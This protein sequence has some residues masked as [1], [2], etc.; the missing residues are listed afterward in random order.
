LIKAWRN[1]CVKNAGIFIYQQQKIILSF[2]YES[3][4]LL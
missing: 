2:A 3:I 1:H 4:T